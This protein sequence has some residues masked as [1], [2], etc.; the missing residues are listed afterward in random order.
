MSKQMIWLSYDL[1]VRGDYV[2]LYN[3]LDTHQAKECGDSV[4]SLVYEYEGA[5]EEALLSDLR[6]SIEMDD[7]ARFYAVFQ[8]DDSGKMKG[9]FLVGRRRASAWVGYAPNGE[10]AD[11]ELIS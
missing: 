8:D 4:A 3:W 7:R 5:L 9:K 2:G 1:G 11:D 10:T 6:S